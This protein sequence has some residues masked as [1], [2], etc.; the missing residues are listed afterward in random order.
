MITTT[1]PVLAGELT[2]STDLLDDPESLRDRART[3]GYLFFRGLL[4]RDA[5]LDVRRDIL[6]TLA[7]RGLIA[8]DSSL[9]DGMLDLDAVRAMPA[10]DMRIDIGVTVEAYGAIQKV[11]SLHALPHHPNLISLYEKL[12]GEPVF[13]HPR[14][15]VRAITPHPSMVPTPAHQ[16]FPLVQGTLE[17]WTCWAPLGDAPIEIGPLT[18][19]RRSHEIGLLELGR[20]NLG[21]ISLG[22]KLCDTDT[23]W[24]STDFLAGD[25]LTF[26]STTIHRGVR[27]QR[28]DRVRLSMDVRY[29][30]VSH[31]I[32]ERSLTNHAGIPWDE[33][34]EGWTDGTYR[35]YWRDGE[36]TISPWDGSLISENEPN[37]IC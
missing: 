10:E 37:R 27:A 13:V 12:F 35:Y 19:L 36:P 11:Q 26:P 30:P 28:R 33:A 34:Y 17:T 1:E 32:E 29:Q 25:V 18:V 6:A 16:D 21:G 15:I 14:H 24:L 9:D 23:D 8:P 20:T 4:P 3:D 22:V 2:D 7:V 31:P 5:V